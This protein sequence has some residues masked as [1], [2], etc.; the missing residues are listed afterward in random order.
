MVTAGTV[1]FNIS[2][3]ATNTK[4]VFY[5]C[6]LI[7]YIIIKIVECFV[8]IILEIVHANRQVKPLIYL[9]FCPFIGLVV[10]I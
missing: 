6:I 4:A 9:F 7:F 3:S 5:V 10:S 2:A 8:W 1:A